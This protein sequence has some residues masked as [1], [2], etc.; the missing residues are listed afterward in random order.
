[1]RQCRKLHEIKPSAF[2]LFYPLGFYIYEAPHNNSL[3]YKGDGKRND[4]CERAKY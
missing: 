2:Q 4:S 1:M 3:H